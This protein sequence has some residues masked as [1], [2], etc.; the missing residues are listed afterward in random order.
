MGIEKALPPLYDLENVCLY[1]VHPIRTDAYSLLRLVVIGLWNEMLSLDVLCYHFVQFLHGICIAAV[2]VEGGKQDDDMPAAEQEVEAGFQ[3][4]AVR[5]KYDP[6]CQ[7]VRQWL[8]DNVIGETYRELFLVG[9]VVPVVFIGLAI[10]PEGRIDKIA[11]KECAD[12]G[13]DVGYLVDLLFRKIFRDNAQD[14]E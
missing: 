8:P 14:K 13:S 11:E 3:Q 4:A 2:G 10:E 6:A 12:A 7:R 1:Q 5:E 9:V